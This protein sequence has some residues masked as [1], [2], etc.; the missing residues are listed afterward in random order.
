M[1]TP[2]TTETILEEDGAEA[3]LAQF[4]SQV[5]AGETAIRRLLKA[6]PG[7]VWGF[8]ELRDAAAEGRRRTAM[9]A[10]LRSLDLQGVLRIDYTHYTVKAL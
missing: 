5:R 10:A 1:S 4:G 9:G 6:E 2:I 7:R 8:S 3:A